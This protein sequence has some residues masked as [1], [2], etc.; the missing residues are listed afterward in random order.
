MSGRENDKVAAPEA[1]ARKVVADLVELL[2]GCD[3]RSWVRV[4]AETGRRA[5]VFEAREVRALLKAVGWAAMIADP[6]GAD[7]EPKGDG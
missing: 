2:E 3:D 6:P 5:I 4:E 1:S 7:D